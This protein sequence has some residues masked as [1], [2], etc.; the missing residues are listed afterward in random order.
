MTYMCV[1]IYRGAADIH[2]H[3][4]FLQRDEFILPACQRVVDAYSQLKLY[5]FSVLLR[6]RRLASCNVLL[7]VYYLREGLP[8]PEAGNAQN[9][10]ERSIARAHARK[11]DSQLHSSPS[12][13]AKTRRPG[14][15]LQHLRYL[16]RYFLVQISP[17]IFDDDHRAVFQ[18]ANALTIFLSF[19]NNPDRMSSP[20][21][22]I[23]FTALASSLMLRI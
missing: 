1:G 10:T 13:V 3:F 16:Y 8:V 21:R 7:R 19:L 22:K 5:A 14:I 4:A 11:G 2:A 18:V 17:T 15:G 20:G 9:A 23:D 6:Y 12:G